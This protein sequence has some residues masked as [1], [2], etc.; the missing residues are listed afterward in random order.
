MQFAILRIGHSMFSEAG[1]QPRRYIEYQGWADYKYFQNAECN[2]LIVV[3]LVL[4]VQI[5]F[6]Y[7]IFSSLFKGRENKL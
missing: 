4:A 3:L 1:L 2:F 6:F 5:L 7:N